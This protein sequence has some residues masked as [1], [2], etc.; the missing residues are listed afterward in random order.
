MIFLVDQAWE[1]AFQARQFAG[2][3]VAEGFPGHVDIGLLAADKSTSGTIPAIQS[4]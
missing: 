4:T 3:E 1:I 2:H